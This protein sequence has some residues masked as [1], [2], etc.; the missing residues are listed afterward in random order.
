[1]ST[2]LILLAVIVVLPIVLAILL[3][4][5]AVFV[6]FGI[7]AGALIVGSIGDDVAFALETFFK[8]A[9]ANSA[10]NLAL[11]AIPLAL[12]LYF[13]RKS[14]HASQFILQIVPLVACG[15]MLAAFALP[16]L[17]PGIQG[18]I[19]SS[20]LGNVFY[21]AT[22]IIIAGASVLTLLL[23]W[24]IYRYKPSH[25]HKKHKKH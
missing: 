14:M 2:D 24:V 1:M 3:R 25:H 20:D 8:G 19:K 21:Q 9:N 17:S 5:S 11:L 13:L 18:S 7:A 6:Y 12:T 16:E 22:D 4:V 23:T 15:L 10:V